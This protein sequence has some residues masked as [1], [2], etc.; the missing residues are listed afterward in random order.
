MQK[1]HIQQQ[2]ATA[3]QWRQAHMGRLLGHAMRRFDDTVLHFMTHDADTP[4]HLSH[5]ADGRKISSA[6]IHIMRHLP[7]HGAR[8]AELAHAA[9]ISRQAMTKILRQ[10]SGWGLIETGNCTSD[11]RGRIIRFTAL[12]MEWLNAFQRAVAAAEAQLV[13]AVGKDVALVL[14]MGLEAYASDYQP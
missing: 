7:V 5:L 8:P 4:L 13:S 2:A 14:R 12:G 9:G 11:G 10:C 6:H 3:D 1:Q